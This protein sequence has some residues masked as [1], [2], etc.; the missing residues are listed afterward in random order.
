MYSVRTFFFNEGCPW[1]KHCTSSICGSLCMLYKMRCN[2]M[3]S[4][5]GS[6]SVPNLPFGLHAVIGAR[7]H[8]NAYARYRTSQYRWTFIPI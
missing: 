5:Y 4:L 8:F 2:P 6:L 1:V 7:R 3:H